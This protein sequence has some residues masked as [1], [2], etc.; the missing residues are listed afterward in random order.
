MPESASI[1]DESGRWNGIGTLRASQSWNWCS[2]GSHWWREVGG[3]RGTSK[4]SSEVEAARTVVESDAFCSETSK[5]RSHTSLVVFG[6]PVV[7][8]ALSASLVSS[9]SDIVH[10]ERLHGVGWVMSGFRRV[11]SSLLS[12]TGSNSLLECHGARSCRVGRGW[13]ADDDLSVYILKDLLSEPCA[14]CDGFNDN[15]SPECVSAPEYRIK[16]MF[17][18]A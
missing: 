9:R 15:S 17:T 4:I 2:A 10:T 12:K 16:D 14:D 13:V 7:Q 5:D 6:G 11:V 8:G 3:T 1:P 18:Y